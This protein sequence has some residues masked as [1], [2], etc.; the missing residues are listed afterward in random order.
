MKWFEKKYTGEKE[1]K[2]K[3]DLLAS[4]P[5]HTYFSDQLNINYKL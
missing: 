1:K 3:K 5:H 4:N 2:G